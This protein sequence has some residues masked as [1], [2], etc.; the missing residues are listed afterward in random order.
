MR[1][2]AVAVF[3]IDVAL[4]RRLIARAG[5]GFRP[6]LAPATSAAAA[7][8]ARTHFVMC[9]IAIRCGSGRCC[10]HC[11]RRRSGHCRDLRGRIDDRDRSSSSALFRI[12]TGCNV[13]L[14]RGVLAQLGVRRMLATRAT[15]TLAAF[16]TAIAAALFLTLRTTLLTARP[17]ITTAI[18]WSLL[19]RTFRARALWLRWTI[20]AGRSLLRL[21]RTLRRRS[22]IPC[23]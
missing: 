19:C 14:R 4:Y 21:C 16:V 20:G 18:T 11:R 3:V 5:C 22:G 9:R 10:G 23:C 1:R 13:P 8:P 7:T 6:V 2:L 15:L 17:S 12:R